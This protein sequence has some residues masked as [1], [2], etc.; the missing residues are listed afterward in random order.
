MS[1]EKNIS[2]IT[3][4]QA[5]SDITSLLEQM[6]HN[7]QNLLTKALCA[8][9]SDKVRHKEDQAPPVLSEYLDRVYA[10]DISDEADLFNDFFA[11]NN[12]ELFQEGNTIL[13][14]VEYTNTSMPPELLRIAISN[15]YQQEVEQENLLQGLPSCN[16][17][18]YAMKTDI[19]YDAQSHAL[20]A[21]DEMHKKMA[22]EEDDDEE[23]VLEA[24][25]LEVV[26]IYNHSVLGFAY[27]HQT[28]ASDLT[29][30]P[31]TIS[32]SNV[33]DI[34]TEMAEILNI[35]ND[36]SVFFSDCC[37]K[38]WL[39]DEN[40][41]LFICDK[42]SFVH[43][44]HLS[45]KDLEFQYSDGF[46]PNEY[47]FENTDIE[48]VDA[49]K[50]HAFILG[51][52]I[53]QMTCPFEPMYLRE[54]RSIKKTERNDGSKFDFSSPFFQ[55]E[56]GKLLQSLIINTVT[57]SKENR[58][59]TKAALDILSI[60]QAKLSNNKELATNK[61]N[62]LTEQYQDRKR[63]LEAFNQQLPFTSTITPALKLDNST[64]PYIALIIQT[65]LLENA[66]KV[67]K[68]KEEKK[69]AANKR[70]P[71]P[72]LFFKTGSIQSPIQDRQRLRL[73][74]SLLKRNKH[75]DGDSEY[76]WS[77]F[78]EQNSRRDSFDDLDIVFAEEKEEYDSDSD[79]YDS[80]SSEEYDSSDE[81]DSV[82]SSS[83]GESDSEAEND[84]YEADNSSVNNDESS[85]SNFNP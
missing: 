59:G 34:A 4:N 45:N 80:D 7:K 21:I 50:A 27:N 24:R 22:D 64:P 38:N 16:A 35:L 42:K 12:F 84:D 25:A 36:R 78:E 19:Y 1:Q 10:D 65:N 70:G 66:F 40:N 63:V 14:K 9:N 54:E 15:H 5:G 60:I 81:E 49:D 53:Y 41:K 6:H 33:V 71:S 11:K 73:D 3:E 72:S 76:D 28:R 29:L 13:F 30:L 77:D 20:D 18:K 62:E 23:D 58:L 26:P 39:L 69:L 82:Y 79:E 31:T 17:Q 2:P 57:E 74:P 52:N 46:V 37:N 8:Y 51:K 85:N 83:S 47:K 75:S 55:S 61:I 43:Q 44:D 68:N 48:P 67:S 56:T 32:P